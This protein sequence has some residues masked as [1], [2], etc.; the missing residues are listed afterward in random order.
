VSEQLELD[1]EW[2]FDDDEDLDADAYDD[3]Q[4]DPDEFRY[5]D[6]NSGRYY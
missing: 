1:Y 3:E 5:V 4:Y 2:D 6:P